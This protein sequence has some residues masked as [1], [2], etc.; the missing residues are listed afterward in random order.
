MSNKTSFPSPGF[1]ISLTSTAFGLVAQSRNNEHHPEFLLATP[2]HMRYI[3]I[4]RCHLQNVTRNRTT[5]CCLLSH[6]LVICTHLE[7]LFLSCSIVV[8]EIWEPLTTH[9]V[10]ASAYILGLL[11]PHLP[12]F[13]PSVPGVLSSCPPCCL[14]ICCC[15]PPN[16]HPGT[17]FSIPFPQLSQFR[18]IS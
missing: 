18:C 10:K 16:P 8:K 3:S 14:S 17:F 13:I 9:Q 7:L 5:A 12:L 1:T 2:R 4:L 15:F 6:H 11:L